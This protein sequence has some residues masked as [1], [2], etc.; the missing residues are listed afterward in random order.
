MIRKIFAAL[1]LLPISVQAAGDLKYTFLEANYIYMNLDPFDENRSLLDDFGDGTGVKARGA[2]AVTDF[3]FL[4][5]GY[6]ITDSKFTF[7]DHDVV[8][9]SADQDVKRLDLG[10]GINFPVF[11]ERRNQVDLVLRGAYSDIDYDSFE[12]GSL[13]G[14][15]LSD[16][17]DDA[18]DGYFVDAGLRTQLL[19]RL[20]VSGGLRYTSIQEAE[21]LGI[22][23]S[24]LLEVTDAW[25]LNL[26]GNVGDDI[27]QIFLGIRYSFSR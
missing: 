5:A 11:R 15:G 2:F 3:I 4:F 17:T 14:G 1:A 26:E 22:S 16:L 23:G 10:G 6:S 13:G 9:F 24:A 7:A 27:K 12:F 18:T 8:L 19:G 20:E 25:G 21:S